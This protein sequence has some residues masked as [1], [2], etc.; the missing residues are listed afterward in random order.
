[1][2]K[3]TFQDIQV[4]VGSSK[5]WLFCISQW[6]QSARL[7][8]LRGL[9]GWGGCSSRKFW[10]A[11]QSSP[12]WRIDETHQFINTGGWTQFL[13]HVWLWWRVLKDKKDSFTENTAVYYQCTVTHVPEKHTW[14][15]NHKVF[16]QHMSKDCTVVS[17]MPMKSQVRLKSRLQQTVNV[18]YIDLS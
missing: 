11:F 16:A 12:V 5:C 8:L 10:S 7:S 3:H 14:G 9:G 4:E 17:I 2:C 13:L 18:Y 6:P 1:M 15:T